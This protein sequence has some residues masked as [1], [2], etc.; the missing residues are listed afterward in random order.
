MKNLNTTLTNLQNFT[1][2]RKPLK[3]LSKRLPNH[4]MC[5]SGGFW[6]M[7]QPPPLDTIFS[8]DG[9]KYEIKTSTIPSSGYGLFVQDNIRAS[10]FLLYYTGLKLDYHSWIRLCAK[11]PRVKVYSIVEDPKVDKVDDLFYFYGDVN[12]GNVAG[13][14]NSSIHC[15]YR[16]NV[17]YVLYPEI[18]PWKT[19]KG[20]L[21]DGKEFGHIGI[22]ALKDITIGEE[23][24]CYYEF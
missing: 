4:A 21:I 24:L 17:E 14:I 15:R 8:I 5:K 22:R 18:P 19:F 23:L 10:Q 1:G 11:N 13:Y 7:D 9:V 2:Q 16:E 6:S 12:M 3:K 20:E